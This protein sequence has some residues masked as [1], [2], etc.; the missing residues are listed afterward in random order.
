MERKRKEKEIRRKVADGVVLVYV[1]AWVRVSDPPLICLKMRN[2]YGSRCICAVKIEK[3]VLVMVV[4]MFGI[5]R[6]IA[7]RFESETGSNGLSAME[8]M[9]SCFSPFFLLFLFIIIYWPFL[10]KYIYTIVK[11][12]YIYKEKKMGVRFGEGG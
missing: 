1:H 3:M 4:L 12:I 9:F 5:C 7:S 11:N 6:T 10:K 2:M 8:E